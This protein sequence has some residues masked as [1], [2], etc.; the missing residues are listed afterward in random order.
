MQDKTS[1]HFIADSVRNKPNV[2]FLLFD[3]Y[4]GYKSLVD[5]FGFHND[6]L[7]H[8]LEEKEMRLLPTYTNYD[9]TLFSLSPILNIP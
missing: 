7:Y 5:S 9:L 6:D 1:I 3:E 8:F 2:Y 4:P